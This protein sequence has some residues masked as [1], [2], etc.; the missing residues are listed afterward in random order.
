MMLKGQIAKPGLIFVELVCRASVTALACPGNTWFRLS[1]SL[2]VSSA[3]CC[4][5]VCVCVCVSVCVCVCVCRCVC[6]CVFACVRVHASTQPDYTFCNQEK[7]LLRIQ[8]HL[9]PVSR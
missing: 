2:D 7:K 1:L 8:L 4:C 3:L 5:C 6:V 9:R